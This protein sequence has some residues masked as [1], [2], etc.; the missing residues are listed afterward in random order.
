MLKGIYPPLTTPFTRNEISL[1]MLIDNLKKYNKKKLSGY[2]VLGS[3]GESVFLSKDE[4]LKIISTVR[5]HSNKGKELIV[6]TGLE[7]IKETIHLTNKAAKLG[8]DYA[9][10]ITPSFYKS[11]ITQKAL[12]N[13]YIAVA[14]KVSIPVIIYNVT[15]FTNVNIEADTVARLAEHKNIVGIKTSTENIA[16]LAEIIYSTLKNFKTFVGTGSVLLDGLSA[17]A[18][19][20]ILA[21]ANVA[22]DECIKIYDLY[23]SGNLKE[24]R[25][26][27]M[28]MIKVNRAI[29]SRYGIAGLKAA[30]GILGYYG[31]APRKPLPGLTANSI[32][33]IRNILI[34][35]KLLDK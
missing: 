23:H 31:G 4:K 32:K 16:Q 29:T 34:E 24:A 7:S 33:T 1:K 3:N 14:D 26:I 35:A 17:G 25:K 13:Y 9:M 5:E 19:G 12:I 8:A 10:I 11:A 28:R 6:G 2:V 20:G 27:Q 15:K 21:L 22:P 30:M 18:A